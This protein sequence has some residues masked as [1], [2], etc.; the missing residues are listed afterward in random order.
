MDE[1]EPA[2]SAVPRQRLSRTIERGGIISGRVTITIAGQL[3]TPYAL[4]KYYLNAFHALGVP[5]SALPLSAW[6]L[7]QQKFSKLVYRVPRLAQ[8]KG[9]TRAAK[10]TEACDILVII[11]GAGVFQGS[12]ARLRRILDAWQ[13]PMVLVAPDHL[14]TF[15]TKEHLRLWSAAGGLIGTFDPMNET[16]RHP[17]AR[18][19]IFRLGFGYDPATHWAAI[20]TSVGRYIT[21]LG[22]WDPEREAI[23]RTVST[24]YPV[25]AMGPYWG[26]ARTAPGLNTVDRATVYGREAADFTNRSWVSLNLLRPQNWGTENMRT[27]EV[28]AQGALACEYPSGPGYLFGESSRDLDALLSTLE[29]IWADTPSARRERVMRGQ[30]AARP[31]SYMRRA[32]ELL[33]RCLE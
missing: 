12:L 6:W 14:S 22:T 20:P 17:Y 24:Q 8:G 29:R 19:S 2:A 23:L 26:R 16:A 18:C 3:R 15:A 32:S 27:Y 9:L 30:E 4:A 1:C 5:T 28:P 7:E 21:F 33:E 31:Y 13:G 10:R 25:R 11:K